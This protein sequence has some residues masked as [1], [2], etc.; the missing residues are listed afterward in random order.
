[1]PAVP[2]ALAEAYRDSIT[3]LADAAASAAMKAYDEARRA[4]PLA[5]VEDVRETIKDVLDQTLASYGDASGELAATMYEQLADEFGADVESAELAEP[6]EET[7][8]YIDQ[9]ARYLVGRL[10]PEREDI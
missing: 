5:S 1:M 3:T 9:R 8:S 2:R 10:V 7:Y 6:G 4:D